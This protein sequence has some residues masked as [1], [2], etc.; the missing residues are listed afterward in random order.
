MFTMHGSFEIDWLVFEI[1]SLLCSQVQTADE[2]I[3]QRHK[4]ETRQIEAFNFLKGNLLSKLAIFNPRLE[5]KIW[6]L[7]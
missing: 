5:I 3:T 6:G 4:T 2:I 7:L 1:H